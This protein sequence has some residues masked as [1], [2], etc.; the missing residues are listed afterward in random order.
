MSS[1]VYH[2]GSAL[3]VLATLPDASIDLCVSSSACFCEVIDPTEA[4]P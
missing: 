1:A 4:N 3:K 2:I